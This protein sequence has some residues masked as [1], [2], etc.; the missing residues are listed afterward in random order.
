MILYPLSPSSPLSP[1]TV[2]VWKAV[3]ASQQQQASAWWLIAQPD[4][5]AL[6][7]ELAAQFSAPEFPPLDSAVVQA[8]ALHDAGWAK[9]DGGGKAG[10]GNGTAP[11]PPRDSSG[12]P[13]AF[14]QAPVGMFVEAWGDS[15]RCAEEKTGAIGGLMVSGHFRRLAEHRQNS[16]DDSPEDA[17]SIR[18]FV[19]NEIRQDEARLRRQQ[20]SRPEVERLVDL[21]QFCDLLS[22]YLCCGSRASVRF[23]QT[24]GS[25]AIA[26]R[27]D[28]GFCLL[29]PSPFCEEISL[30]VP[31]RR[32]PVSPGEPNTWVLPVLLR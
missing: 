12:R 26:L 1:G 28:G 9:Y 14:L 32:D 21:L 2:S 11:Q 31:V 17:A 3:A 15:I 18:A 23:P 10:G 4:H 6:A 27:R 20:R 13:L 30:G 5:S 8:I 16:V 25:R 19:Q 7:G 24:I 22:L 29:E